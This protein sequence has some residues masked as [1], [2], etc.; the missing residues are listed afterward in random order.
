MKE[1][2]AQNFL[3][4]QWG[5]RRVTIGVDAPDE[6]RRLSNARLLTCPGCGAL[7]VLH[8]GT[9]RTHHFAHLPGS[10]CS[11]PQTEPET[12]E[13]RAGKLLIA[14][15]LRACL[16][17]AQIVVEAHIIETNQRADILIVLPVQN[18][19]LPSVGLETPSG[20]EGYLQDKTVN[21]FVARGQTFLPLQ[22]RIAIEYQCA[23]MQAKEWRRRHQLYRSV[24]IQDLWILGGSRLIRESISPTSVDSLPAGDSTATLRATIKTTTLHTNELERGLLWDGAPLLFLDAVG[25]HLPAETLARFR[26]NDNVQ[27]MRPTGRLDARSLLVLTFPF[28]LMAWPNALHPDGP[29]QKQTEWTRNGGVEDKKQP[30]IANNPQLWNWLIQ[31]HRVTP[32]TL[33]GFFGLYL[34]HTLAFACEARAWQAAL[35]YRFIHG[36]VGDRWWLGEVETW[37]RAYLPLNRPVHL[38]RLRAALAEYQEVLAAAGFL[39][40]PRGYNRVHAT[41]TDDLTTLATP[42]DPQEVLRLARY[43]RTLDREARADYKTRK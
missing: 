26:P 25:E 14:R 28:A 38:P 43:R 10:V 2:S 7:V 30:L 5:E 27:A 37:A 15:W 21:R 33:P 12:E 20:S 16:P 3:S 32:E 6:L 11:A 42:P 29:L 13:H 9:V 17:D 8:A 4:A 18:A 41:V 24:G 1:Q 31:R 22:Q 39:S 35:Y 34:S 19:S 36:R 40:L 23:N